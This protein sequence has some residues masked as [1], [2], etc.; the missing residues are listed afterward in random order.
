MRFGRISQKRREWERK[1]LHRFTSLIGL[2]GCLVE[3]CCGSW[4]PRESQ[5]PAWAPRGLGK[6]QK[7]S[8]LGCVSRY[9]RTLIPATPIIPNPED[10]QYLRRVSSSWGALIFPLMFF[11]VL[12]EAVLEVGEQLV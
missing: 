4:V 7:D 10:I 1:A 3:D 5:S 8:D 9:I 12:F 6:A 11:P 2:I